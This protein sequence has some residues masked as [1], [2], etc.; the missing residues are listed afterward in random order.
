MILRRKI[1]AL[2]TGGVAAIA[3]LAT[4]AMTLPRDSEAPAVRMSG[5]K[6]HGLAGYSVHDAT[7]AEIGDVIAVDADH[8]GRTRYV[9]VA[10]DSGETVRVAAFLAFLDSAD[11]R[12]DLYLP[13][14]LVLADQ[15]AR[16]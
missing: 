15:G 4:A 3:A 2:A 8:K 16:L 10:L 1:S 5:L 13:V 9:R 12:I 7:G 14:D 6:V 11:Q